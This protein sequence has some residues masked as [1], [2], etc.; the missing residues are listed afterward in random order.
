MKFI[1]S[2]FVFL[3]VLN[4]NA[5]EYTLSKEIPTC[6]FDEEAEFVIHIASYQDID[7]ING[8]YNMFNNESFLS[9]NGE[10]L[11]MNPKNVNNVRILLEIYRLIHE[12]FASM[13]INTAE[14]FNYTSVKNAIEQGDVSKEK[15]SK[16]GM[17]VSFKSL[18]KAQKD[19]KKGKLT[20][21]S[22]NASVIIMCQDE[23]IYIRMGATQSLEVVLDKIE[24][25]VKKAKN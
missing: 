19:F 17:S 3:A 18:S 15:I 13:G 21:K 5:Q 7:V 9:E 11:E 23:D 12:R 6:V 8:K 2:L 20:L 4:A 10:A 1:I 14:D 16:Y 22:L 25:D 24:E